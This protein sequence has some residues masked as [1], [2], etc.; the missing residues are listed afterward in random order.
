MIGAN[1]ILQY[2]PPYKNKRV[3]LVDNQNTNDII[4][5]IS[6]THNSNRVNYDK[7]S[8]KFWKG[9][10]KNT[11]GAL[12]DFLK[13]NVHYDI[14]PGAT[15]TVKTP[16]AILTEGHGDCKHYASF[17]VGVADSLNRKG[18]PIEG[19]YMYVN[20]NDSSNNF[21]HVFGVV[22]DL[23]TGREY[24]TDPIYST[25]DKRKIYKK[26][27][28]VPMALIQVSGDYEIGARKTKAERKA[29]RQANRAARQANRAARR[30]DRKA[31]KALPKPQRKAAKKAK[32]EARR[33]D[34]KV[35][36]KLASGAQKVAHVALKV[37]NAVSRNAF[38]GVVKLNGF[39]MASKM[40]AKYNADKG[41]ADKLKK[42]WY[43]AGGDWSK[44]KQ[45]I[46]QGVNVW[47]K[48]HTPTVAQISGPGGY[49]TME[50][51]NWW[52][53]QAWQQP[54]CNCQSMEEV[55]DKMAGIGEAATGVVT[56]AI[57]AAAV[58]II[59][60]LMGLLRS[61]GVDTD[62]IQEAGE[63][64]TEEVI[65]EYNDSQEYPIDE[66]DPESFGTSDSPQFGIKAYNDPKDGTAT[67]QYTKSNLDDN[68]DVR[69]SSGAL[70]LD[71]VFQR[72]K[73]WVI[74]NKTT[75]LWVGGG[76][77]ALKYG[78]DLIKSILPKKKRGR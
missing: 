46:N 6:S 41:W 10:A 3:V 73:D 76:V 57:I 32:R 34:K 62:E 75:L 71:M 56:A 5:A 64:S 44:L 50:E 24:W 4:N 61:S 63:D 23:N 42:Q 39:R 25:F 13:K 33:E 40:A 58:P 7:I 14:E 66:D 26:Q 78:P 35:V 69:Y 18:Y 11:A 60:K 45:A 47:N 43:A 17:I 2:L 31:I 16:S 15:Q 67:I 70:D 52:P 20:G 54:F 9:N 36:R 65:D 30:S 48:G 19:A 28:L 27:K 77:L 22:K 59:L 37:P 51:L 21:H 55:E 8:E 53:T 12:F 68:G 29:G 72:G 1:D 74:E 38:L 49:I